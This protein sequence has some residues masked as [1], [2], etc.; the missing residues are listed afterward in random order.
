M[1]FWAAGTVVSRQRRKWPSTATKCGS[2]GV[3]WRR[4]AVLGLLEFVDGGGGDILYYAS[5]NLSENLDRVRF[6]APD[7][8]SRNMR[9]G[10]RG[11]R[12]GGGF[13]DYRAMDVATYRDQR[14]AAFVALLRHRKL[15]PIAG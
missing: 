3:I 7:V 15:M 1:R 12:D 5:K 13:Y 10:R 2:G 4:C 14:L 8:V 9:E 11:L 6:A